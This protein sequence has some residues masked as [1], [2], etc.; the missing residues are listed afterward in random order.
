MRIDRTRLVR[1]IAVVGSAVALATTVVA[2]GDDEEN[3]GAGTSSGGGNGGEEVVVGLI[4]KT[5]TNPF[6]V[7]MKEGAESKGSLSLA[8]TRP[9]RPRARPVPFVGGDAA[10]SAEGETCPFRWR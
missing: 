2:C 3:G 6:F 9:R 7:K 10:T 4:T 5:E 8:V 1:R